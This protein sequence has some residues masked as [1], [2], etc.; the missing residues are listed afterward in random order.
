VAKMVVKT[1]CLKR[2]LWWRIGTKT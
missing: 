1:K 2:K